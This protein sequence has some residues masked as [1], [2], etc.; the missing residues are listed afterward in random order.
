VEVLVQGVDEDEGVTV[1]RW[2][3]QAP[4][5]D[6]LVLL[7]RGNPGEIVSVRVIDSIGY[8]LEGEVV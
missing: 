5:I 8:D 6:G 3:G 7:D 2:R 4:E 1:G